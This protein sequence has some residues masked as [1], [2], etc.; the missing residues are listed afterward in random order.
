MFKLIQEIKEILSVDFKTK[1]I[2]KTLIDQR[3]SW[4][5]SSHKYYQ[6]F[7]SYNIKEIQNYNT[8]QSISNIQHQE[9]KKW[10]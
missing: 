9:H 3:T 8:N 7:V 6:D 4:K 1:L 10:E 5:I 2:K